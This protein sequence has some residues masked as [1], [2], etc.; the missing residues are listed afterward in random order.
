MPRGTSANNIN[1]NANSSNT[2]SMSGP[3]GNNMT[4]MS[5]SLTNGSLN[6][7]MN[8]G[9][10]SSPIDSEDLS[11]LTDL[12][13]DSV[14]DSVSL[15]SVN[16][17]LDPQGTFPPTESPPPGYMSEDGDSPDLNDISDYSYSG[18]VFFFFWLSYWL[19]FWGLMVDIF[20]GKKVCK[21]DY[22]Y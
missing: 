1:N 7:S 21:A 12:T 11:S 10:M 4:A 17:S 20:L 15:S 16:P 5:I 9:L 13:S 19:W 2:N 22:I 18:K 6:S 3:V 8:G 14:S